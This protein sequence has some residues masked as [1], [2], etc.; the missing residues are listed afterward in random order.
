MF[1]I[2]F[3]IKQMTCRYHAP[4]TCQVFSFRSFTHLFNFIVHCLQEDAYIDMQ[5]SHAHHMY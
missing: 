4:I 5:I 1:N 2:R 3:I